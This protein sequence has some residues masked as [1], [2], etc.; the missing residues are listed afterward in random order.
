MLCRSK[1][2]WFS[3][4][5]HNIWVIRTSFLTCAGSLRETQSSR[6]VL[7]TFRCLSR[8]NIH[9]WVSYWRKIKKN[10][11]EFSN[12]YNMLGIMSDCS[13]CH[14]LYKPRL[15]LTLHVRCLQQGKRIDGFTLIFDMSN[16][17]RKM[18]WRPGLNVYMQNAEIL[19]NNYPEMQKRMFIINGELAE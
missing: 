18:L 10:P 19:Q 16:F 2:Q 8:I 17:S 11:S 6:W 4:D 3:D 12:Q 1:C 7:E 9:I 15:G 14:H 5:Q 13:R